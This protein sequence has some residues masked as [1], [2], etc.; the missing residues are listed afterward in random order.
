MQGPTKLK[1]NWKSLISCHKL[2]S[3]NINCYVGSSEDIS[4]YERDVERVLFSNAFKRLQNKTQ[5]VPLSDNDYIHNRYTHSLEVSAV[6]FDIGKRVAAKV[7]DGKLS[8]QEKNEM[9]EFFNETL[10]EA[11]R[12][13]FIYALANIV[14]TGCLI[15]D[16]G[17]PPFGHQGEAA[18]TEVLKSYTDKN[19]EFKELTNKFPDIVKVEGNA[20][21]LRLLHLNA[22]TD[23]TAASIVSSFKYLRSFTDKNSRYKKTGYYESEHVVFEEL[24]MLTTGGVKCIENTNDYARHPLT[25]LVEASDDISYLLFDFEDFVRA[26][27]IS[28]DTLE[29]NF[30]QL[31]DPTNKIQKSV[32]TEEL[33]TKLSRLRSS[34]LNALRTRVVDMFL[35]NYELIMN[36][37]YSQDN[38]FLIKDKDKEHEQLYVAG[39]LD[40]PNLFGDK[41]K[42]V[43][44]IRNIRSI[45]SESGY[46]HKKV[47][48]HGLA[49][50]NVMKYL[51]EAFL[52]AYY[53]NKLTHSQMLRGIFYKT[54]DEDKSKKR[55][56]ESDYLA[57]RKII[58]ELTGM[59]DRYALQLYQTF[60][61]S[62]LQHFEI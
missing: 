25:Y 26:G 2:K 53:I 16:I 8:P 24:L 52:D 10:E 49:G 44:T 29:S 48:K 39:L 34:A 41:D 13:K 35:N 1:M 11:T 14:K 43:N 50:Y 45:S 23:L 17:N 46:K 3:H 30:N 36:G 22:N 40:I 6:G 60:K 15:H 4:I 61:G 12:F 31:S 32:A 33:S 27:F 21:T 42:V 20:Q 18:I 19:P 54:F 7:W 47:L 56:L 62:A 58:D 51:T 9:Q 37:D 55:T 28:V 5:V 38:K 57:V 59:T